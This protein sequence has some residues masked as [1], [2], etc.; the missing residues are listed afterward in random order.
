VDEIRPNSE[1]PDPSAVDE[2][3]EC[4]VSCVDWYGNARPIFMNGRVFALSSAELIEASF[5]NGQMLERQRIAITGI[6]L[7]RR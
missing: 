3:Y 6:P 1:A 5:V 2:D 7:H 4:E